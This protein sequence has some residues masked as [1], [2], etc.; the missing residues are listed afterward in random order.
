MKTRYIPITA[1]LVILS[2]NMTTA[3]NPFQDYYKDIISQFFAP[4]DLE[5]LVVALQE[6]FIEIKHT[7]S[8]RIF[9]EIRVNAKTPNRTS[10]DYLIKEKRY[11]LSLLPTKDKG[12]YQLVPNKRNPVIISGEP[13][14]EEIEYILY[15]PEGVDFYIPILDL[16]TPN[17]LLAEQN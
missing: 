13:L 12:A 3:Q 15:L 2:F 17:E 5:L 14:E 16:T 8:S 9:I 7:K 6:D 4:N 10:L 1:L 11:H